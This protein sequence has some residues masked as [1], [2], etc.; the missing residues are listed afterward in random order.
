MCLK[1]GIH[2]NYPKLP[3][4]GGKWWESIWI[5]GDHGWPIFRQTYTVESYCAKSSLSAHHTSSL[6]LSHSP[7]ALSLQSHPIGCFLGRLAVLTSDGLK[8]LKAAPSQSCRILPLVFCILRSAH[9]PAKAWT[10]YTVSVSSRLTSPEFRQLLNSKK[11]DSKY[12][13][14][15]DL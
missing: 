8:R 7:S 14:L 12:D 6:W 5:R 1:T 4:Q 9:R 2:Q 3:F 15:C 11:S 13:W 10:H